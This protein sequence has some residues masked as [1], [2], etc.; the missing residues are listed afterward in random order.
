MQTFA[1][2]LL[3]KCIV[4]WRQEMVQGKFFLWHQAETCLLESFKVKKVFGCN[5][6]AYYFQCQVSKG[7]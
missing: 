6:R 2:K 4:L 3:Q 1:F 5:A 7:S